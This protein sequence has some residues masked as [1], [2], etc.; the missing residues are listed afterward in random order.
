MATVNT[1]RW[2][3]LVLKVGDGASPEVFTALCSINAARN[4]NFTTNLTEEAIPDCSDLEAVMWLIREK[5]SVS[6]EAGGSGKVDKANVKTFADWV[7]DK[8]PKNCQLIL[9]DPTPANV[10]TFEGAFHLETF[11]MTGDPGS[12]TVSGEIS[13]KS[14]GEVTGTYGA[15]VGGT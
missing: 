3:K 7:V 12:P 11:G 14:T 5:V 15:N 1:T 2:S 13:L 10:I 4:V 6:V 8:D 9:D